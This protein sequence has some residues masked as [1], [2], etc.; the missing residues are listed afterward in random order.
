MQMVMGTAMADDARPDDPLQW[1]DTD[2][3]GL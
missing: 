3:D 2:G 1:T